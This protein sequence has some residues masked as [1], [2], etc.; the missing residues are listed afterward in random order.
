MRRNITDVSKEVSLDDLT[1]AALKRLVGRLLTAKD[2]DEQA[3]FESLGKQ[4]RGKAKSEKNDL[5]DLHE[6]MH[7][8]YDAPMVEDGD[9]DEDE[10]DVPSPPSKKPARATEDDEDLPPRRRAASR[11]PRS[12]D[13]DLA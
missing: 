7:G 13:E 1:N 4:A 9:D 12:R 2:G 3:V 8:K 5:A 10:D 11:T 6:E